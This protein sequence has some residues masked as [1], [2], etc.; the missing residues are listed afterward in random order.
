AGWIVHRRVDIDNLER[1][2]NLVRN[3]GF[4]AGSTN[5]QRYG[6]GFV[7]DT[8]VAHSGA[9]SIRLEASALSAAIQ[10][11][12]INQQVASP[13]YISGWSKASSVTAGCRMQ[14][15]LYIDIFYTDGSQGSSQYVCFNGGTH[16]WQQVERILEPAKPVR[17]VYLWAMFQSSAPG[18]AWFDDLAVGEYGGDIREFD[19]TKILYAV[20]SPRPWEGTDVLNISTGDGLT[21]GLTAAGGAVASLAVNGREQADSAAIHTGGFFVRDVAGDSDFVHLGGSVAWEGGKLVYR[22]ADAAL[23]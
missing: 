16:G 15:S 11:V 10:E 5:W 18:K 22:G 6:G 21:L 4:E 13:I 17:S 7:V 20:P 3:A 12:V 9:Q 8:S 19:T 23:G 2:P 1:G 14:Y